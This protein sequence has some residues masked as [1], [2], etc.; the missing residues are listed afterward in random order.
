M[1]TVHL[2]AHSERTW[3]NCTSP[4]CVGGGG[5]CQR[6]HLFNW[7]NEIQLRRFL[8][9]DSNK[10]LE[11]EPGCTAR[12]K[13]EQSGDSRI[14]FWPAGLGGTDEILGLQS[15]VN[16]IW[17]SSRT[18]SSWR[19]RSRGLWG[20][21]R[22][23]QQIGWWV[24]LLRTQ[25]TRT[26]RQR[27]ADGSRMSESVCLKILKRTKEE[28]RY[29]GCSYPDLCFSACCWMFCSCSYIHCFFYLNVW[30]RFSTT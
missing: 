14:V 16:E 27:L 6:C 23:R 26:S 1:L 25:R 4:A 15:K 7:Q 30:W 21:E 18:S 5:C 10:W 9:D 24:L 22:Q 8:T 19:L 29:K 2:A 13:V 12:R 17:K 3:T 11:G 20:P 28:Q